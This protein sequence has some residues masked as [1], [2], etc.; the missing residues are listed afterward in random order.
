[1]AARRSTARDVNGRYLYEVYR[2]YVSFY[3]NHDGADP[4]DLDWGTTAFREQVVR[5]RELATRAGGRLDGIHMDST[6]GARRWGAVNDFDRGHWANATIPLTFSYANGRVAQLG[7]LSMYRQIDRLAEYVRSNGMILS[8][9]FNSG[10]E[11][12]LGWLGADR[13][14]YFGI[15]QGLPDKAGGIDRVD[16]LAML[17]RTLAYQRPVTSLDD[18]IGSGELTPDETRDRLLQS[19]FYG[20]HPGVWVREENEDG[21][22]EPAWSTEANR[23]LF[24]GL[25]PVFRRLSAAGWEPVTRA[26]SSNPHVWVERYGDRF[27]TLRNETDEVQTFGLSLEA[28]FT[29]RSAVELFTGLELQP[30]MR[31]GPRRTLV[32]DFGAT[33]PG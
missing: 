22:T 4:G 13:I 15:E 29:G 6:S 27:L 7:A 3:Q 26:R 10:P 14:D 2:E 5:A 32:L 1:M 8:A 31:I 19:L 18:S 9:N 16:P 23:R 21:Q 20:I 25:S 24:G 28:P 11:R 30:D 17:K 33:P 12:A